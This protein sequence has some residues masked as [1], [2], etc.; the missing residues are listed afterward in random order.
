MGLDGICRIRARIPGRF[1]WEHPDELVFSPAQPLAPATTYKA[2]IKNAVLQRSKFGR[3]AN[4]ADLNFHTPDLRLDNAS[5]TWVLQD[6]NSS[7]AIP[8]VELQFNYPVNPSRLKD[9]LNILVGDATVNYTLQTLSASDRIS[10]RLLNLKMEDKTL[11][12]RSG[13]KRAFFLKAAAMVSS[14]ESS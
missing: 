9:K 2:T 6:E 3:I 7:S 1:R 11:T 14:P 10:L 12:Q 8:Q 5:A 4:N 13:L